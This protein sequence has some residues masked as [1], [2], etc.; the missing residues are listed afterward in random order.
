MVWR[1][2]ISISW[3]NSGRQKRSPFPLTERGQDS[4]S[5]VGNLGIAG[6]AISETAAAAAPLI[7]YSIAAIKVAVVYGDYPVFLHLSQTS[8]SI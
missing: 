4:H 2:G 1:I 3:S 7:I 8:N 6:M 5:S